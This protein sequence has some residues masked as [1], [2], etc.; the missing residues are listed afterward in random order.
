[1]KWF[2]SLLFI[3]HLACF[4]YNMDMLKSGCER[5]TAGG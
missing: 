2:V 1:M 5:E 4:D 3:V